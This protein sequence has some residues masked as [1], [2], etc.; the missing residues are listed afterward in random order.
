[1]CHSLHLLVTSILYHQSDVVLSSKLDA[2]RNIS[3]ACDINGVLNIIANEAFLRL[4]CEGVAALGEK[5]W[6]HD[7]RRGSKTM[8]TF[9]L[10]Y[11]GSFTHASS[12]LLYTWQIPLILKSDTFRLIVVSTMTWSRQRNSGNESPA[13]SPVQFVPFL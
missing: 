8:T 11:A 1:M 7:G 4:K 6:T 5:N 12:H 13:D 2:R 9:Q 10:C 3:R